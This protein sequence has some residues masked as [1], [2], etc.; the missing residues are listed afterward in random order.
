MR[1]N[2][3]SSITFHEDALGFDVTVYSSENDL[4]FALEQIAIL[5]EEEKSTIINLIKDIFD[6]EDVDDEIAISDF[7]I[8]DLDGKSY[9]E[10]LYNL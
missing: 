1:G 5:F 2:S 6:E 7:A 9:Y 4:C 3:G 8:I 10:T